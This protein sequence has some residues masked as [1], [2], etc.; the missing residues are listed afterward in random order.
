MSIIVHRLPGPACIAVAWLCAVPVSAHHSDAG[1]DMESIIAFEGMVTDFVW[2]NPHVYVLVDR[3][4][5]DGEAVA[6]ELQMGPVNVISRRGWRRDTLQPGDRVSVR[7]HASMSGRT[8]G[9]IDSIDKDGGL[10]LAAAVGAAPA[11]ETTATLEGR[12]I[13]DRSATMSYPGGFDGFFNALMTLNDNGRSAQAAYDPLSDENPEATCVGRPTPAALVSTSLYLME[14]D[15]REEEQTVVLHSEYFDEVRTVYMDG[16]EHPDPGERFAAG[17]SIGWWEGDTLVVD[18]R[19]FEDHRSPYQIGVPSGGQKH[20]V[21]RYRL[22]EDGSHIA[23]EFTLDDPEFLAEPMTHRR[24]LN[25]SPHMQM[26][27]GECDPEA[28]SRFMEN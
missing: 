22:T 23:L 25:Y 10:R 12:W 13:A 20:V 27:P 3:V 15:I 11:P 9:I 24:Q 7:A 4:G 14:I 21:E 26:Y 19:N 28:T 16:R 1:I 8:Y 18:T 5:E 6:W 2:R 17:H